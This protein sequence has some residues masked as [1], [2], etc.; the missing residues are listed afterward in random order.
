MAVY[1]KF[2][3]LSRDWVYTPWMDA[4][5]YL[6]RIGM[7]KIEAPTLSWLSCMQTYHVLNVPFETLSIHRE[8]ETISLDSDAL[9]DKIVNRR[10]GGF[11]YELNGLFAELLE[12]VGYIVTRISAKV[13][14]GETEEFGPEFDHLTLLV[15][16]D[17]K[18]LVDVGFGD[19]IRLPLAMPN[20]DAEDV[21][22]RFRIVRNWHG[23]DDYMYEKMENGVWW[24]KYRFST[25]PRE[26]SEF[27]PMCDFHQFSKESHF[28]KQP[29]CSQGTEM[30]RISLIPSRFIVTENGDSQLHEVSDS[31]DFDRKLKQHFDINRNE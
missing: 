28:A 1:P 15:H 5:T 29:I 12:A 17:K 20:G 2:L 19:A 26:M 7:S 8:N 25:M 22:G 23:I 16:L 13:F 31:N 27:Q 11:C 14:S 6:K 10:R 3:R 9:Y 21:E 30:G 24:P 18:Y 4:L